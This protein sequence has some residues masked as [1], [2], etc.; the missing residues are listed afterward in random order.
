MNGS[1]QSVLGIF[2]SVLALALSPLNT[3]FRRAYS[4]LLDY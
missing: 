3:H 2:F 4:G 1:A